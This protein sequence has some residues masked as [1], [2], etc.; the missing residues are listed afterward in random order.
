L[1]SFNPAKI[2]D[3][4]GSLHSTVEAL[5]QPVISSEMFTLS[6]LVYKC[7]NQM[8]HWKGFSRLKQVLYWFI[9]KICWS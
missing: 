6:R 1:F 2:L 7:H 3:A 4:H 5:T 8:R 9:C